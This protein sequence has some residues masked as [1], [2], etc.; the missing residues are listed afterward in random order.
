MLVLISS[1]DL[2]TFEIWFKSLIGILNFKIKHNCKPR[3]ARHITMKLFPALQIF[4]AKATFVVSYATRHESIP[5]GEQIIYLDPRWDMNERLWTGNEIEILFLKRNCFSSGTVPLTLAGRFSS[6]P[7]LFCSLL[8]W[9]QIIFVL[10][11]FPKGEET[12]GEWRHR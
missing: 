11:P 7:I 4:H 3:V 8:F 2:G 12:V 6:R 1:I 10:D 9:T 5:D